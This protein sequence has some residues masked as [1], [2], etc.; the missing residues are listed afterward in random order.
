M[1]IFDRLKLRRTDSPYQGDINVNSVLS[2]KDVDGNFIHLKGRDI[3]DV[4]YDNNILKLTKQ[5]GE[6]YQVEIQGGSGGGGFAGSFTFSELET[7]VTNNNLNVGSYYLLNDFETIYDRPDYEED[8]GNVIPKSVIETVNSGVTEP[9]LL[10]AISPNEFAPQVYSP[11]FPKDYIEYDFNY[12]ETWVNSSHAKGRITRRVDEFGNEN[13]HDFKTITFKRYDR[14]GDEDFKWFWDS[15]SDDFVLKSAFGNGCLGNIKGK[16]SYQILGLFSGFDLDNFVMGD[17]CLGNILGVV[18]YNNTWENQN[19]EN[20]WG[21]RNSSNTW[22]SHND[23]IILKDDINNFIIFNNV[24][25][26]TIEKRSIDFTGIDFSSET[27]LSGG[28]N[29]WIYEDETDGIKLRYFSGGNLIIADV[30]D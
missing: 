16:E 4:S 17:G 11:L 2:A 7:L 29:K 9:L 14:N 8:D 26:V 25:N 6:E 12:N 13:N 28:F 3:V 15:G 24:K 22:G 1:S 19:R 18:N 30:N 27:L 20:V 10:L 5:D 23:S 21:N